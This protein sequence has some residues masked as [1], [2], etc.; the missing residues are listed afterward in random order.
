MLAARN[1]D[2]VAKSG[3]GRG[4]IIGGAEV[5]GAKWSVGGGNISGRGGTHIAG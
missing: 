4:E 3:L 2:G 5:K 1:L